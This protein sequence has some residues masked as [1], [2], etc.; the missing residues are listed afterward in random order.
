WAAESM[1]QRRRGVIVNV[2]SIMS[3]QAAGTCPAYVACKGAMDSLTYE[4]AA[5]YG[6]VGIRVV[7][8][9]PG[10]IDT[11]LSNDFVDDAGQ[12]ISAKLRSYSEEMIA[13]GRW[14]TSDEI[15]RLIAFVASDEASYLTGTTVVADGGW[16]H[17]HLPL[18]LRRL[19]FKTDFS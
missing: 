16:H 7:A 8:V 18:S 19:Q 13:L 2:S 14:G 3:R 12:N 1:H 6:P 17:Q 11:E 15:A 4:L 9:S 5:L 10:A